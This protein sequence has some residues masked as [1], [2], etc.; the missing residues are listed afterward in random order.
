MFVRDPAEGE[1]GLAAQPGRVRS[2]SG[3]LFFHGRSSASG[4]PQRTHSSPG[5]RSPRACALS[6][7]N[8]P[9]RCS[10]N[11]PSIRSW[12][13][14]IRPPVPVPRTVAHV[15]SR[16]EKRLH[17]CQQPGEVMRYGRPQDDVIRRVAAVDGE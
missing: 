17:L 12:V 6:R 8:S 4:H 14:G 11:R 3:S 7:R 2:L 16:A 9:A 5:I 15:A 1:R 10:P 13:I